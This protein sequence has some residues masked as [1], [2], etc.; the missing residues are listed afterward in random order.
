MPRTRCVA[1]G[2]LNIRKPHNREMVS[3]R[4][5][6]SSDDQLVPPGPYGT[7]E[8]SACD[9]RRL[10]NLS[11]FMQRRPRRQPR[12]RPSRRRASCWT[13]RTTRTAASD[14]ELVGRPFLTPDD[15]ADYPR[16]T[17]S[18]TGFLEARHAGSPDARAR[19]VPGR[20]SAMNADAG[21]P[22][23]T[24]VSSGSAVPHGP[25]R[26]PQRPRWI[27]KFRQISSSPLIRFVRALGIPGNLEV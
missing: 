18:R 23:V 16:R 24:G 8:R 6:W 20:S 9:A 7:C 15:W 21:S 19:I 1:R 3:T 4:D 25:V 5:E 11:T 12:R 14:A 27:T 17:V 26:S 10:E 22:P 2:A 13:A